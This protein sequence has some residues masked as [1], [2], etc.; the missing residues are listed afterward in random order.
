MFTFCVQSLVDLPNSRWRGTSKCPEAFCPERSA[1]VPDES[2]LWTMRWGAGSWKCLQWQ[3][4][5]QLQVSGATSPTGSWVYYRCTEQDSGRQTYKVRTQGGELHYKDRLYC[6][7][8]TRCYL[9]VGYNLEWNSGQVKGV[10]NKVHQVPPVMDIVL[11]TTIPHLFDF[12]PDE[13]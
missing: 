5:P 1:A 13:S 6:Y 10:H 7:S 2:W 4:L 11:K 8:Q 3:T 12:C 9:S